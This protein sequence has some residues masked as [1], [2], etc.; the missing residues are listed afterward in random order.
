MDYKSTGIALLILALTIYLSI[1]RFEAF[2]DCT[3]CS[4]KKNYIKNKK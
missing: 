3:A 2:K 1:P 4:E